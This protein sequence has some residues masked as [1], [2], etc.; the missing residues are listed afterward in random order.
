[1]QINK[2]RLAVAVIFLT[3]AIFALM[4]YHGNITANAIKELEEQKFLDEW[5]PENCKC[6]E[7]NLT[8]C[9][10]GFKLIGNLCKNSELKTFTNVLKACSKYDCAGIIYNF[11]NETEKWEIE[12]NE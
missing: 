1:M 12:G 6:I 5:L 7:H 8:K 9:S 11:N 2:F 4:Y 3:M 10:E